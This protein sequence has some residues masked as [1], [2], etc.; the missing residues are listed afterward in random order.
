V[1]DLLFEIKDHIGTITLNRPDSLNSF[2]QEMIVKWIEALEEIKNNDEVYVGVVTG[3]GRAFCAGGD[4]KALRN[5]EGFMAKTAG[6][7]EN[8]VDQPINVKNGLWK[9]IQRIPLL[10]EDIDKPMIAAINGPAIGAGLDMALMCDI[11]FASENAKLGEGYVN[12]GI[13]PGDGGGFYLPR[14]I[15]VDKALELLWTGRVLDAEE[16]KEIGLVTHVVPQDRLLDEVMLFARKL[17]QGPQEVLKM[18]KR[19]VYESRTLTLKQSLDL[20][21]SFM[22]IAVHH[23]DHQEAVRAMNEKRKP[24]YS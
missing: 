11:R 5:G 16:A 4:T 13:V 7:K 8:F 24:Q 2:S 3:H 21:S 23:P 20:V 22:A 15:G 1:S 14:L 9:F 6:E 10:M 12:A 18:T 17:T 19:I